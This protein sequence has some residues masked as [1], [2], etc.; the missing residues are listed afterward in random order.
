LLKLGGSHVVKVCRYPADLSTMTLSSLRWAIRQTLGA[1]RGHLVGHSFGALLA[2][3]CGPALQQQLSTISVLSP[4]PAAEELLLQMGELSAVRLETL[5]LAD[6]LRLRREQQPG[7]AASYQEL[8]YFAQATLPLFARKVAWLAYPYH[9]TDPRELLR[10]LEHRLSWD[11]LGELESLHVRSLL[12]WGE[13]D[14][15][16]PAYLEMVRDRLPDPCMLRVR[17]A[18]HMLPIEQPD[19]VASA[20]LRF[21]E[22]NAG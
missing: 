3:A 22:G 18:G 21:L 8:E 1:T 13:H 11:W 4:V 5:D 10:F 6:A 9:R 14:V 19:A 16:P 17:D 7:E 2:L 12:L 20:L 15:V